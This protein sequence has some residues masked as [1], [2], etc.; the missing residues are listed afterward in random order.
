MSVCVS[1]WVFACVCTCICVC[2][3][4]H[5]FVYA[6]VS[7]FVWAPANCTRLKNAG[8]NELKRNELVLLSG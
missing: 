7:V 6:C 8:K 2:V 3:C 5:E 1:E 4:V